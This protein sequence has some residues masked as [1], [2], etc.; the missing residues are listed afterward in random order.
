[1]KGVFRKCNI[2]EYISHVRDEN[3]I[4]TELLIYFYQTSFLSL[5][6][7]EIKK[8]FIIE[9]DM[10][11]SSYFAFITIFYIIGKMHSSFTDPTL[12]KRDYKIYVTCFLIVFLTSFILY[13]FEL[14]HKLGIEFHFFKIHHNEIM[15]IVED[16]IYKILDTTDNQDKINY[17]NKYSSNFIIFL[18]FAIFSFAFAVNFN[19]AKKEAILDDVLIT[20][21]NKN[22]NLL[23]YSS[24]NESLEK[25]KQEENID[26]KEFDNNS[27]QNNKNSLDVQDNDNEGKLLEGIA[28]ICKFKIIVRILLAILLFDHLFKNILT[29]NKIISEITFRVMLL[30]IFIILD[31]VLS[32]IC[33][34]YHC[35]NYLLGNYFFMLEAVEDPK[36]INLEIVRNHCSNSLKNFWKFFSN[37]FINGFLP[38][39]IYFSF[40]NRADIYYKIKNDQKISFENFSFFTGFL[41]TVLYLTFSGFI[42]AR[43]IISNGFFCFY[44]VFINN[45]KVKLI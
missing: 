8:F 5:I 6:F 17:I 21:V 40:L 44:Q 28:N 31:L 9:E 1:M 14:L 38:I 10:N 18:Y 30:P 27:N 2:S 41:E 15:K 37:L 3:F 11:V 35:M 29:E 23:K 16:R 12:A 34:K 19:N 25:L 20:N 26:K 36:K 43:C 4:D 45:S 42:L 7:I 24:Q 32:S 33:M 39:L 22:N 13:N